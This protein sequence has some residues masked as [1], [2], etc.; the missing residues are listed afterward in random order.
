[1]NKALIASL[2]LLI[3]ASAAT[4]L[5]RPESMEKYPLVEWMSDSN[6]QRFEQ[7]ELFDKW[8]REKH[9]ELA[10]NKDLPAFGIKLSAAN[11]QST[12][13]QAVSGVAGLD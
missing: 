2:V 5:L 3:I 6:P 10:E 4:Y 1:M 13:I 9:P 7:T 8:L 11:N 12:I